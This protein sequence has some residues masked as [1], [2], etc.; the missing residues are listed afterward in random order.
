MDQSCSLLWSSAPCGGS[1]M[2]VIIPRPHQPIN[3][4]CFYAAR[5][6]ASH[7]ASHCHQILVLVKGQVL[8]ARV[9][10]QEKW[11]VCPSKG[12]GILNKNQ[13]SSSEQTIPCTIEEGNSSPLYHWQSE[14]K[15]NFSSQ[16][17]LL[18]NLVNEQNQASEIQQNTCTETQHQSITYL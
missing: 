14:V 15:A 12:R 13:A 4:V 2:G 8:L 16:I 17:I 5:H 3:A 7:G 9:G 10:Q 1:C 6:T 11:R 18:E